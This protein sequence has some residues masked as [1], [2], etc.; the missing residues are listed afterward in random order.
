MDVKC[1]EYWQQF[2][3][4]ILSVSV[5]QSRRLWGNFSIYV[6]A[7]VT[8]PTGRWVLLFGASVHEKCG[9]HW[10]QFFRQY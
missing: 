8:H 2:F 7:G 5:R 3:S 10:Q 9:E 6:R 1:G 4:P